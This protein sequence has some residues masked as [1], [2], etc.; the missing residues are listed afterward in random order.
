MSILILKLG[1]GP[2]GQIFPFNLKLPKSPVTE[3]VIS[4]PAPFPV[5]ASQHCLVSIFPVIWSRWT[6]AITPMFLSPSSASFILSTVGVGGP[7]LNSASTPVSF[8]S[9]GVGV[10]F[11]Q[12]LHLSSGSVCPFCA[13]SASQ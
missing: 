2:N 9:I 11:L 13:G 10:P 3:P 8:S 6:S 1:I 7:Y 4:F 12:I 5:S